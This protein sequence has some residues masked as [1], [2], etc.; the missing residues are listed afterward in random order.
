M[1]KSFP[2]TIHSLPFAVR[3]PFTVIHGQWLIVNSKCTVNSKWLM[4]NG[5]GGAG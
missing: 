5:A 1:T 3:Y 4:V 2:L